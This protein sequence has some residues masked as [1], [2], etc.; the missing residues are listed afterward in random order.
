MQ[1]RFNLL[2]TDLCH[3][4][5]FRLE[6]HRL[7]HECYRGSTVGPI[8]RELLLRGSCV[9]VLPYD[10]ARDRV[11]LLE[12]FRVG[13]IRD[14]NGAWLVEVVAGICEP[15]ESLEEVAHR[16]LGEEVGCTARDMKRVT[17]FYLSPGGS[18]EVATL[19]FANVDSEG[20]EGI[21][22]L[23]SEGED[24]RVFGRDRATAMHE[25][26]AGRIRSAP[27]II[28][29]QWLELSLA[30]IGHGSDRRSAIFADE[31]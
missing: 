16:E 27:A 23:G 2:Q 21:H 4:G 11:V 10:P 20:V 15:G 22:G 1:Y 13:A 30:R 17:D 24:I 29:L 5:F 8:D 9:V 28:A 18:D 25:V 19:F 3:D 12:Q 26:Y 6:R 14:P 31:P 7:E